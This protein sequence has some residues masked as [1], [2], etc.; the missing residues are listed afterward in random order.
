MEYFVPG[1]IDACRP[2]LW[3]NQFLE[4]CESS[5]ALTEQND[6]TPSSTQLRRITR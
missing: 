1:I 2:L 6:A 3:R 5:P 4:F